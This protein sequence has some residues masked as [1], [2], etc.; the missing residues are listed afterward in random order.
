MEINS[1]AEFETEVLKAEMPVLVSFFAVGCGPCRMMGRFIKQV[2]RDRA[3]EIKIVKVDVDKNKDIAAEYGIMSVPS[4]AIIKSGKEVAKNM[5]I[6]SKEDL[7]D[8]ID[9]NK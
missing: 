3:E 1:K 8:F 4:I 9:D 6:L 2:E 7:N 5:G